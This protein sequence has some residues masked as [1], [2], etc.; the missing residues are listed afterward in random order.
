MREKLG[1]HERERGSERERENDRKRG[2]LRKRGKGE[3]GEREG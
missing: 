2:G 1:D 3:E